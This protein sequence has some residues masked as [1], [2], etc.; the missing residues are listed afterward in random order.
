MQRRKGRSRE[1]PDPAGEKIMLLKNTTWQKKQLILCCYTLTLSFITSIRCASD[2]ICR[3]EMVTW[4]DDDKKDHRACAGPWRYSYHDLCTYND[5]TC[6]EAA[7]IQRKNCLSAQD[8]VFNDKRQAQFSPQCVRPTRPLPKYVALWPCTAAC[9]VAQKWCE[10]QL[11]QKISELKKQAGIKIGQT[12]AT[13]E[14]CPKKEDPR[15]KLP[16]DYSCSLTIH[17]KKDEV[18]QSNQCECEVYACK[19]PCQDFTYG[20]S[21]A[22]LTRS[23]AITALRQLN[24]KEIVV[25]LPE[26]GGPLDCMSGEDMPAKNAA[27]VQAKFDR[28]FNASRDKEL[29]QRVAPADVQ[30]LSTQLMLIGEF[31]GNDLTKDQTDGVD[32]LRV[33]YPE[34]L[35]Q[36]G[37]P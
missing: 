2:D 22:Q 37:E 13:T 34:L 31:Y 30:R 24:S 8:Q 25:N 4:P 9:E 33:T 6:G 16:G 29:Q 23:Q 26:N 19:R 20:Y 7:C 3:E 11:N 12:A 28:V 17:Y 32:Y 15:Y 27:Q 10:R 1:N 35:P 21:K 14:G 18:A 36:C 5:K